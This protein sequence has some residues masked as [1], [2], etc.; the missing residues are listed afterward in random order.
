M[1]INEWSNKHDTQGSS[2]RYYTGICL[3]GLKKQRTTSVTTVRTLTEEIRREQIM[4]IILEHCR[5]TSRLYIMT[6]INKA[7]IK[8]RGVIIYLYRKQNLRLDRTPGNSWN[9]G[10]NEH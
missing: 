5:I 6:N 4:K 9:M 1:M 10:V 3:M 7:K 8:S 2:L